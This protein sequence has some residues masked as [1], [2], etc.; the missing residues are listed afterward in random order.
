[1]RLRGAHGARAVSAAHTQALEIHDAWPWKSTM[2]RHG[3]A[4]YTR[5][6]APSTNVSNT[7][8]GPEEE[9]LGCGEGR[10]QLLE[11]LGVPRHQRGI[12]LLCGFIASGPFRILVVI[13]P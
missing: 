6:F 9:G 13:N 5:S 10:L 4:G 11:A 3:F 7:S 12:V 1:M 8:E 2:P